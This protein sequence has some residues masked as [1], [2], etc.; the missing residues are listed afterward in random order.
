M[1]QQS[2]VHPIQLFNCLYTV[3]I[4]LTERE[5]E[6]KKEEG[7]KDSIGNTSSEAK[8]D[9]ILLTEFSKYNYQKLP[10]NRERE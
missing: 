2:T 5:K 3:C 8:S 7:E 9:M 6:R 10:W 1:N 4:V